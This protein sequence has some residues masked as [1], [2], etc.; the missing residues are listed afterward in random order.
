MS[1]QRYSKE[2]QKKHKTND[3]T[4]SY[5]YVIIVDKLCHVILY[6]IKVNNIKVNKVIR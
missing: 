6:N 4:V 1:E 5:F 3:H 2:C